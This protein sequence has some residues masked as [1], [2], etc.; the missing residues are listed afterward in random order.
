MFGDGL[1]YARGL[2]KNLLHSD[3]ALASL[4]ALRSA[5]PSW[6]LMF[7]SRSAKSPTGADWYRLGVAQV[8]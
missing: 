4:S 5:T 6:L 3:P 7:G 1:A 8:L 2:L